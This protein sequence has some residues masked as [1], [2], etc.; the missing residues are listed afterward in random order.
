MK[1][2]VVNFVNARISED[3]DWGKQFAGRDAELVKYYPYQDWPERAHTPI[4]AKPNWALTVQA[5]SAAAQLAGSGG[6]VYMLSGHGGSA[7]VTP[8]TDNWDPL[9]RFPN[10]GVCTFDIDSVVKFSQK[11]VFYRTRGNPTD[12]TQE[13]SDDS[14]LWRGW[15]DA[16]KSFVPKFPKEQIVPANERDW[17]TTAAGRKKLRGLYDD[18]G[19]SMRANKVKRFVFL[20]CNLGRSPGMIDQIAKDWG[21]EVGCYKFLTTVLPGNNVK[22]GRARY[23]LARDVAK[24]GSGTNVEYARIDAMSLSDTTI[25]YVGKP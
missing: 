1:R 25:S 21:V 24:I 16:R 10:E 3:N 23:I 18:I 2:V 20:S 22:D 5:I 8:H 17:E 4:N 15:I 11:T 19:R 9:C 13:E 7:C 14:T 12:L 6:T